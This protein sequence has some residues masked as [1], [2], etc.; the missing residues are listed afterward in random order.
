MAGQQLICIKE[1]Q[2]TGGYEEGKNSHVN[3]L[4]HWSVH[5]W[6]EIFNNV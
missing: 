2:K 4:F 6:T 3:V 5:E 1:A